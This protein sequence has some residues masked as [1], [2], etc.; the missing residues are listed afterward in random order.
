MSQDDADRR[1]SGKSGYRGD[2]RRDD[3]RGDRGKGPKRDYR[4]APRNGRRDD[5][6][7]GRREGQGHG[8]DHRDGQRH[9]ARPRNYDS[10]GK[11]DRPKGDRPHDRSHFDRPQGRDRQF[12]GKRDR[13]HGQSREHRHDDRAPREGRRDGQRPR[14][15]T[16]VRLTIPSTPEKI[17][18]KGIDCEVNGRND[19]ALRL[20]LHGAAK[21]SGGCESNA[22]R[23]LR[24]MG[25]DEFATA[26]GRVAKDSPEEVLVAF[27]YLCSTIDPGYDC[28]FIESRSSEGDALAIYSLIRLGRIEGDDPR[29]DSFASHADEDEAMVRDGL[30][31][32]VRKKD[33]KRAEDNLKVMDRRAKERQSIGP[34]FIKAMKGDASSRRRLEELAGTFPDAGFLAGYIDAEDREAYLREGMQDHTRIILSMSS[35]LGI[36]DTPFGRFL[37]A[38]KVQTQ[39][40]DW[41]Q[42]MINAAAAGSDD[43]VGE[44]M[45][46]KNRR[47]VRR[48]LASMYLSRADAAGLVGCYD[49]EDAEHL[50]RYC[51]LDGDRTVEVARLMGPSRGIDWLK[52]GCLKGMDEC[53][54]ELVAMARSGEHNSK[55]L[56]YTLHDVGE[57]LESAKLYMAMYGDRSLPSVKWLSKVCEDAAA[58]EFL[59]SRFEQ[60]GE[61]STFESIFVDDGYERKAKPKGN[62]RGGKRFRRRS[63]QKLDFS[64]AR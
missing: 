13:Q 7:G 64:V 9:D 37:S 34:A 43:A 10:K 53:R 26:R 40:G 50:D 4:G 14:E 24:E 28:A 6:R 52:R 59:R 45:P 2:R 8:Q 1:T 17:L 55:Q 25:R 44:L 21:L 51:G 58:K 60:M 3:V 11:G 38:K 19:L 56:V 33:S 41:I 30:K 39:G 62:G 22:A 49:G 27:D 5:R 54:R 42:P 31:L 48:G 57:E 23:M 18:F 32:L 46:I 12:D 15:Q 61:T 20:Y 36:S 47:D 63:V 16:E 29:I 35:E